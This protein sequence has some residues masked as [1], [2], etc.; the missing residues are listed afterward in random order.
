LTVEV[1][2]MSPSIFL[3]L[4]VM[5][6]GIV[7]CIFPQGVAKMGDGQF[8]T[9]IDSMGQRAGRY[10]TDKATLG[11]PIALT[12]RA[13]PTRAHTPVRPRTT[14]DTAYAY[15]PY[16]GGPPEPAHRSLAPYIA[17]PESVDPYV[18]LVVSQFNATRDRGQ[19]TQSVVGWWAHGRFTDNYLFF[20][21]K[22]V[23]FYRKFFQQLFNSTGMSTRWYCFNPN[24]M[25]WQ[26]SCHISYLLPP[27]IVVV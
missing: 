10:P 12:A 21:N 3:R 5:K 18:R 17:D 19:K 15:S 11:H 26:E 1:F 16:A 8:S 13:E 2:M 4:A 24:G 6:V 14:S 23:I 27:E 20:T 22:N 25:I 7:F 9:A